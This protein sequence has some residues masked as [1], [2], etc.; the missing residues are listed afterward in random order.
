L[1]MSDQLINLGAWTPP[2]AMY[3]QSGERS[4]WK[5]GRYIEQKFKNLN[6]NFLFGFIYRIFM[7]L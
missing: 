1:H 6:F 5:A 7:I 3:D 4:R 2:S